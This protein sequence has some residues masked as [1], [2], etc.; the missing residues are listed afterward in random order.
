MATNNPAP[1]SAPHLST[2]VNPPAGV[3]A[4]DLQNQLQEL[5][6][7]MARLLAVQGPAEEAPRE[8]K[9]Y[10][11]Q[12]PGSTIVV[13]TRGPRGEQIPETFTFIE[14]RITTANPAVQDFLD[15]I[16]DG[17]GVPIYSKSPR[18][19]ADEAAAAAAAEVIKSAARTIDKLGAEAGVVR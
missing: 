15:G 1:A 4:A 3:S 6:A 18:G 10:Y 19:K 11:H 2:P 9:T 16:V 14:G 7:Q 12:T 17:P 13:T 8:L 5:Q